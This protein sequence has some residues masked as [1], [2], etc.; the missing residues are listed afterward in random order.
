VL[1]GSQTQKVDLSTPPGVRYNASISRVVWGQSNL[2]NKEHTIE[3]FPG[4]G[5]N[6]LNVDGFM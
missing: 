6:T 3:L 2:E 5:G 4:E 1:D